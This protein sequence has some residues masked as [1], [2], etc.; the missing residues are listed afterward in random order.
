MKLPHFPLVFQVM[1]LNVND[2][3]IILPFLQAPLSLPLDKK[4]CWGQ[5]LLSPSSSWWQNE[6]RTAGK[7][8]FRVNKRDIG[9][10]SIFP[11]LST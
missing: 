11:N 1:I 5:A 8:R 10:N 6:G 9:R 7:Q 4:V 3:I 2:N